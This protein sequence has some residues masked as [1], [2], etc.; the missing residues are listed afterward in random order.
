[1]IDNYN[2]LSI[3]KFRELQNID[4]QGM[5]DIDIQ[6]SIISILN[7][8]AE[9]D[10]INLPLPEYKKLAQA[11]RFLSVPPQPLNTI[12]KKIVI[13]NREFYVVD[14]IRKMTAGQYIDYQNYLS[15][16][17]EDYLPHILSC[18]VIPKGEK[19]GDSDI[20]EIIDL[21]NKELSIITALSISSFFLRKWESLTKATLTYLAWK[22]KRMMKKEQNP[23]VKEKMKE[24]MEKMTTFRSI[25]NDGGGLLGLLGLKR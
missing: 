8:M 7:D 18:F 13:G 5:E 14:D 23:I 15:H 6:V 24:A 22:M 19:Y 9:D 25:L 11:T 4:L 1:M 17:S 3:G 21:F 16:K 20:S 12:P 2:K 10:V